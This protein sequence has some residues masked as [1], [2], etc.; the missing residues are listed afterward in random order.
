MLLTFKGQDG[1]KDEEVGQVIHDAFLHT[2]QNKAEDVEKVRGIRGT[3]RKP[4]LPLSSVC[5][6]IYI[7][8]V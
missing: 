5:T 1:D 4:G 6:H 8:G 2:I 7:H 3:M